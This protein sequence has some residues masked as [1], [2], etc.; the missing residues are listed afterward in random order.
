MPGSQD[1]WQYHETM[2]AFSLPTH[3]PPEI[4]KALLPEWS[5]GT[6]ER[7]PGPNTR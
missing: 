4:L 1:H 5:D 7:F 2:I 3:E 6:Q